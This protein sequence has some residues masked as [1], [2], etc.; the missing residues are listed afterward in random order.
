MTGLFCIGG[1][2]SGLGFIAF[3]TRFGMSAVFF[4]FTD[5]HITFYF[6]S[7]ALPVLAADRQLGLGRDSVYSLY[8]MQ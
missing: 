3:W 8:V 1:L 5:S 6:A 7:C 4:F 2:D